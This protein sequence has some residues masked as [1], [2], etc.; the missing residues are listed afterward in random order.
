MRPGRA[1]AAA[2]VAMVAG[3]WYSAT[4]A[5]WAPPLTAACPRS[6]Y[7]PRDVVLCEDFEHPAS[8]VLWD[9]GSIR[10]VWPARHFILCMNGSF[11]FRDRCAAWSHRLV[12][13]GEFGFYG[14]DARR[15][16]PPQAEFYVRWYQ[17]I[18]SSYT[19]GSLEDKSVLLHDLAESITAYVG[20]SRNHLPTEPN[21]GPG[22]PFIANYQDV[23][24]PE[25]ASGQTKVNRFQNQGRNITLQPGRWYL[26]EW[27]IKLNTPGMSNG[28]TSLWIDDAT[29]PIGQQTL[30][31]HYSDMR[32]LTSAHVGRRFGV[33]RL[34]VYHQRC[35]GIPNSCPPNGPA[36]LNQYQL[37]DQIAVSTS[38][39][40]PRVER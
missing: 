22:M 20:T 13:D 36:V 32:W 10:D 17:Y 12:F 4:Q 40:G 14:Y 1:A 34:S 35:D 24:W 39:I 26:F 2:I 25:A 15:T 7:A 9:I 23:D 21:S 18:S 33:L 29:R 19:W 5:Q 6:V 11:G 38:R 27:Y 16:F 3:G 30:R 8:P 31:M 28:T 37:W